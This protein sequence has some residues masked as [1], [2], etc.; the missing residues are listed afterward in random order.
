MV[1]CRVHG[2]LAR[3]FNSA[4]NCMARPDSLSLHRAIVTNRLDAVAR[5]DGGPS[6]ATLR[7]WLGPHAITSTSIPELV[8]YHVFSV[9][10]KSYENRSST[11]QVVV[12]EG[13]IDQAGPARP[14]NPSKS[15]S[16]PLRKE[17]LFGSP[18]FR[19]GKASIRQI[20]DSF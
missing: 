14:L 1:R 5:P 12:W 2:L 15:S 19:F 8:R 6:L 18:S 10:P 7:E 20:S 13:C 9:P 16:R 3:L 4:S 11:G 17:F